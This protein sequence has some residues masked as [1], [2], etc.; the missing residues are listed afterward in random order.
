M[1]IVSTVN[2]KGGVGKTTIAVNLAHGLALEP[3]SK[4]LLVDA[5]PS[6]GATKHFRRREGAETPYA[7]TQMPNADIHKHL[8]LLLRNGE[9]THCVID[10][11]AGS[12]NITRS[13]LLVTDLVIVP[14]T[15]SLYDY[16][17]AEELMPVLE[18]ASIGA[19]DFKVLVVISRREPGNNSFSKSARDAA[20]EV[21]RSDVINMSVAE[22]GITQLIDIKK[23]ALAGQTIF[24]S[25]KGSTSTVEF[26]QLTEEVLACLQQSVTVA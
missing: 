24:E 16:D 5:D 4:V 7:L 25:A 6:P 22:Q 8:P 17:A 12:S 23:S 15:P 3:G 9:Y 26:T 2:Q 21:F 13:A 19:P 11:P 1:P 20:V 14:V 10:C 18:A